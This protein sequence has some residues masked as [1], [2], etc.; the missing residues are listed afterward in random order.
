MK[1]KK[2]FMETTNIPPEKTVLEI[3]MKLSEYGAKQ[4]LTEYDDE[5]VIHQISFIINVSGKSVAF[6]LPCRTDA[7]YETM[8]KRRKNTIQDSKIRNKF[9]EN[10][11]KIAWRQ[12]LRWVE[13]Q[14]ALVDTGMAQVQEVFLAYAQM[15]NETLYEKLEREQFKLLPTPD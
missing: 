11:K 7:V 8:V 3:Q 14:L 5:G 12:L 2:L 1:N 9:K 13:A 10:A 15:G 4:I 6:K